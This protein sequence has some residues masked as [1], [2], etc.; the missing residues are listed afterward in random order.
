MRIPIPTAPER[1]S[2]RVA[3]AVVLGLT[4]YFLLCLLALLWQILSIL[5]AIMIA[6]TVVW[7]VGGEMFNSWLDGRQ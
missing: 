1:T 4:L 3:W 2:N 7:L 5:M 6:L